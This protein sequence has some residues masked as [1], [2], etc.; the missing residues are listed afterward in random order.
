M[1]LTKQV[2]LMKFLQVS[3]SR[4]I[5]MDNILTLTLTTVVV[6]M[7]LQAISLQTMHII[8]LHQFQMEVVE[9]KQWDLLD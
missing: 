5:T 8:S 1:K 3:T 2:L 9:H 4:V 6:I 7:I